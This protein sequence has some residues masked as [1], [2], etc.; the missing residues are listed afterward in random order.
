MRLSIVG[1]FA[2]GIGVVNDRAEAGAA[3]DRRP[4]QHLEI[5]VRIAERSD[6]PAADGLI[7]CNRRAAL[8]SMKLTSG[9]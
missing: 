8:S 5:A 7:D 1:I 4:L 3:A 6:R 2:F 9:N